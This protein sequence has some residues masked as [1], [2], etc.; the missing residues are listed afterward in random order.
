MR[1]AT[2]TVTL[3]LVTPMPSS[4]AD[5]TTASAA[6]ISTANTIRRVA[7]HAPSAAPSRGVRTN[8][9]TVAIGTANRPANKNA[10]I[11]GRLPA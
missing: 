4:A 5:T 8:M 11:N 6:V 3:R 7:G 1:P 2:A 9:A 10:A